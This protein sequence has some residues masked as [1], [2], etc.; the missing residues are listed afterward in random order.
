MGQTLERAPRLVA[1]GRDEGNG[2]IAGDGAVGGG[3]I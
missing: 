1:V 2:A 3:A